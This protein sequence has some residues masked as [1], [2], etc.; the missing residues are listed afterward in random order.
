MASLTAAVDLLGAP[1]GLPIPA[2]GG[3]H[4]FST[5]FYYPSVVTAQQLT[6][7]I[8]RLELTRNIRV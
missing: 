5:V 3:I 8:V 1:F 7:H 6:V 4:L 2:F